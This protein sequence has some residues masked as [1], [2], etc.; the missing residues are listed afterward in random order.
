M[1]A[2]VA[3]TI[4]DGHTPTAAA[5]VRL[6]ELGA[7]IFDMDGVVTD[8]ASVHAAAWKRLFDNYLAERSRRTGEPFRPFDI[9][10]DYRHYVDGKPRYDGVRDFLRS[11]GIELPE[12]EP[13]DPPDSETVH[14]LGNRK[15]R[16][17]LEA[18]AE[19]GVE[20]YPGTVELVKS[21][22]AARVGVA[23][24]SAS[25]NLGLVL[26][27][28]G[29]D[30]L[31]DVRVGGVETERLGLPGKPEPAVFLEAARR[32][33]VTPP[34][35]A[36]V[37]DA[38]AGVEAGR[39]GG[40]RVVIGVDRT[41]H[42]EDLRARGADVVV[43]DLSEL[44]AWREGTAGTVEPS[45]GFPEAASDPAWLVEI[46]GFDPLGEREVESWL[47]VA[48]G[49]TGTRGS[50]E[51]GSEESEPA[52]YVA[53]LYGSSE[54]GRVLLSGP[55][56]TGLRPRVG[57]EV[58]DLDRG[59][60][61]EH[62]RLLDLR[63]G[64]V[65]RFW[66]QRL[67]SGAE[68]RFRSV[69]FAS[70]ADRDILVLEATLG[71]EGG[72]VQIS[73]G[74]PPPA[75]SGP[76]E[77][78]ESHVEPGETVV[79]IRGRGGGSAAFAISTQEEAGYL[80]RI[81]AVDRS[82]D[83]RAPVQDAVRALETGRRR[84]IPELRDRHR[85]AWHARWR[86]ADVS[87]EGDVELQRALRFGLYHL[88]SSADPESDLASVGARGL[89]GRGYK[90]HVFWDTEVFILPFFTYT[91]PE[92]AR[93]L[94]AY[95]HRTLDA[96]R[97]RAASLGY[98]G[99]L[100]AWE[101]AD[102]GED[103]TPTSAI[104]PDG[105]PVRILTG[106]QEH[107]IAADVAW[108]AWRYWEATGDDDFFAGMGAE[109]I[110]ETARFWRSRA[111]RADDGRYHLDEVIGPDEY[112]EGVRDNAFTNVLARWN[113][114]RA[115]EVRSI[116]EAVDVGAWERLCDRLRVTP[117]ELEEWRAVADGLVDGFDPDTGLYEQFAGFFDLEDIKAADVGDRPFAADVVL[118][119]ERVDGAQV[120][121]QADVLMLAHMLPE[122]VPPN[123]ASANYQYYEPRTS[124][125]SS[126]SPA[127]HA[128]V[129]ARVGRLDDA[130][131]YSRMAAAIDLGNGMG[132]AAHGVHVATMGGLWQ[133]AVIGFGGLRTSR[134]AVHLDPVLPDA[135][136]TL[137]FPIRWRGR[138]VT[139]SFSADELSLDLDGTIELVLGTNDQ[140][141]LQAGRYRS[142]R[143]DGSWTPAEVAR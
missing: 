21:L 96:A 131:A 134:A 72:A 48:N 98:R 7:V 65:F 67:D 35:A 87:V 114:E 44:L 22:R 100:F 140:Q 95:R 11:R 51:E 85:A 8:T 1:A 41:G 113:I 36:V 43:R 66:R 124:H 37:E 130:L 49:R 78:V 122:V 90:G 40:F 56:W 138:R 133:A 62:R 53:G 2:N 59:D 16:Y 116:L 54:H 70:L 108:A 60:T 117:A 91:H 25:R 5:T 10:H 84:G 103:V 123:V 121:K 28:A 106:E 139:V 112:H 14:G 102:T 55:Q 73:D 137:G 15:D 83:G 143:I 18:I 81:V 3:L 88:I 6:D 97:A 135:W 30:D 132:N 17:F 89:S 126:L 34:D 9:G 45:T 26:E 4:L 46:V 110:L 71:S 79:S 125:G 50:V 136:K 52:T 111:R 75:D 24:I 23:V 109:I 92:S 27:T 107:H 61:V 118:G 74:I 77:G 58:L 93:A 120:V 19:N 105:R 94:L 80:R 47:T 119:V 32:L 31:F 99:A 86:D 13:D 57:N 142:T 29:V 42:A 64:M 141:T 82:I 12:G 38:L 115:L 63:N 20:A 39:R 33:G 128:A 69:R 68:A 127:I 76:L 101:S 104:G 129:A